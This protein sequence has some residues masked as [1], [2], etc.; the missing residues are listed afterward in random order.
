[1]PQYTLVRGAALGDLEDLVGQ[2]QA[3]AAL[4]STDNRPALVAYTAAGTY[5]GLTD[6]VTLTTE[7]LSYVRE[8]GATA[9]PDL[10]GWVP[11]GLWYLEH[12]GARGDGVTECGALIQTALDAAGAAGGKA[13]TA[14]DAAT[15]VFNTT[16]ICDAANRLGYFRVPANVH[17][18][19]RFEL[20]REGA[21]LDGRAGLFIQ[22]GAGGSLRWFT[23][24]VNDTGFSTPNIHGI[25]KNRTIED[26]TIEGVIVKNASGYGLGLQHDDGVGATSD[27]RRCVFRDITIINAGN[28]GVDVKIGTNTFGNTYSNISVYGF[29]LDPNIARN[30]VGFHLRTAR[31]FVD[32]I[33]V[34]GPGPAALRGISFHQR[35][36]GVPTYTTVEQ[37][38]VD[39]AGATGT[40]VQG[41]AVE[42]DRMKV[43][44]AYINVP[45]TSTS[46]VVVG[47]AYV[48]LHGLDMIGPGD[49]TG[50]G[51]NSTDENNVGLRLFD[52]RAHGFQQSYD[53]EGPNSRLENWT[54]TGSTL[55]AVRVD[56]LALGC[57]V[58][59]G[60]T[61]HPDTDTGGIVDFSGQATVTDVIGWK[62]QTK[63]Y[64][65]FPVNAQGVATVSLPH[66]LPFTPSLT[67]IAGISLG[68]NDPGGANA[69]EL[70]YIKVDET[71]ATNIVVEWR[72]ISTSYNSTDHPDF[73]QDFVVEIDAVKR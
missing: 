13:I 15:F 57:V 20:R 37:L 29:G 65:S 62:T 72:I 52:V 53:I 50:T 24:D 8:Q 47:G 45:T 6:G 19:G 58:S 66:G 17:L 63:V 55:R 46:A 5:D 61:D 32:K 18:F 27:I 21:N 16:T 59:G 42:V 70:A 40:G 49:G 38:S 54:S 3:A 28:D 36:E 11:A 23:L 1:M 48:T 64:G 4:L 56:A 71:T 60:Y 73:T 34:E 25:Y 10:P 7:G 33:R 35:A 22:E 9:I 68:A 12:F 41:L 31:D 69:F 51:V 14:H 43:G 39:M 30:R 67:D 44:G 2:A 26:Y